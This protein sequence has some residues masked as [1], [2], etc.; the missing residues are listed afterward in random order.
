MNFSSSQASCHNCV[1]IRI[2]NLPD[3]K[4]VEESRLHFEWTVCYYRPIQTKWIN[5]EIGIFSAWSVTCEYTWIKIY[6]YDSSK[7][8][9]LLWTSYVIKIHI[10]LPISAIKLI[11]PGIS[12]YCYK[13]QLYRSV[14]PNKYSPF[15]TLFTYR[16]QKARVYVCRCVCMYISS[17]PVYISIVCPNHLWVYAIY[18]AGNLSY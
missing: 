15:N 12:W 7:N 5:F 13:K 1:A 18:S 10:K 6:F 11:Y 9:I 14:Q 17:K 16:R 8:N 2:L 3:S 4:S